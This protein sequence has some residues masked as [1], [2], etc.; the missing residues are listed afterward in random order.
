MVIDQLIM[1]KSSQVVQLTRATGSEFATRP[2]MREPDELIATRRAKFEALTKLGCNSRQAW[3]IA[4]NQ[5]PRTYLT[6]DQL[7]T[8]GL[9]NSN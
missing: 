3:A 1:A 8:L 2:F 6:D 4:F 9:A 5:N 7:R